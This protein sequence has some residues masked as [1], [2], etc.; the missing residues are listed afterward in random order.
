MTGS[1][2][3][4]PSIKNFVPVVAKEFIWQ[5]REIRFDVPLSQIEF[6]KN[7][8]LIDQIGDVEDTKGNNG[9]QGNLLITNLRLIWFSKQN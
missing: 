1:Q 5:D 4:S 2:K 3:Q 9:E 8:K 7:E 6:R